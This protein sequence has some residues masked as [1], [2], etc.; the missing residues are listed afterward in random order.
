LAP[1]AGKFP[2]HFF[3]SETKSRWRK[4]KSEMRTSFS[5]FLLSLSLRPDFLALSRL[6]AEEEE[7]VVGQVEQEDG[8]GASKVASRL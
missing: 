7:N 3:L 1:G 8:Q 6:E 5:P 4:K 2:C